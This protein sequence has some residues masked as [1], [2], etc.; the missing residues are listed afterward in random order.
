MQGARIEVEDRDGWRKTFAIQ[1]AI[2]HIGAEARND[3]ALEGWRGNGVAPRHLQI[4]GAGARYRL[5]N[6]G[7]AEIVVAQ[8]PNAP[9]VAVLPLC[10]VELQDGAWIQ[11]GEFR[12]R[13]FNPAEQPSASSAVIADE[14]TMLT[15]AG[16]PAV[17][18]APTGQDI[19]LRLKLSGTALSPDRP[20]EGAL[21][22]RNQ[23]SRTGA[24][25]RLEVDGL[26]PDMFE[27]GPGPILF[28]GA[29]KEVA[30]RIIHSRRSQPPVGALTVTLRA[31][32]P[33]AYPGQSATVT[34]TIQVMPYYSHSL[35]LVEAWNSAAR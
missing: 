4:I 31:T 27:V 3:I 20:L 10:A 22:V 6:I 30:F 25:F 15:T 21:V 9:G 8:D 28:P 18:S 14:R 24:Q 26:E 23:G 1:K 17:P 13:F 5:V 7:A 19:G 34:Q 29:E 16:V 12:L 11:L 35:T 32:A 33:D 2:T